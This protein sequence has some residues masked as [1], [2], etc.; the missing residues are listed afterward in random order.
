MFGSQNSAIQINAL[1]T[2]LIDHCYIAAKPYAL[3]RYPQMA[4]ADAPDRSWALN[5]GH[6]TPALT[7]QDSAVIGGMTIGA[8][9]GAVVVSVT[10]TT[11][12]AMPNFTGASSF[13]FNVVP[14]LTDGNFNQLTSGQRPLIPETDYHLADIWAA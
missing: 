4:G 5:G 14:G 8:D 2:A 10:N 9:S 6:G 1:R 12:N 7:I 11:V 13:T 3:D